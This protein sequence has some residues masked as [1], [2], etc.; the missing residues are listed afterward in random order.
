M[1]LYISINLYLYKHTHMRVRGRVIA[2]NYTHASLPFTVFTHSPS[3]T[4]PEP[5]FPSRS[6]PIHQNV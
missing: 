4:L 1:H 3:T 2:S 6:G 5:P